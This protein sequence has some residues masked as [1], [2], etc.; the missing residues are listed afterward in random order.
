M[1]AR[2]LRGVVGSSEPTARLLDYWSPDDELTSPERGRHTVPEIGASFEK[3][4]GGSKRIDS[5]T[6]G[7]LSSLDLRL[8]FQRGILVSVCGDLLNVF[9]Q[10]S[11][12]SQSLILG[13]VN[14]FVC[15]QS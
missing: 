14:E 5:C 2:H 6:P 10:E 4:Q 15:Q 13:Y 9:L 1:L 7:C 3:N 8:L 11:F 12:S